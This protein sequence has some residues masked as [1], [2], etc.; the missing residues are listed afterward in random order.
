MD[1]RL[2]ADVVAKTGDKLRVDKPLNAVGRKLDHR[3][4]AD[5]RRKLNELSVAAAE[6]SENRNRRHKANG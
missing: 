4:R 3:F 5:H 6:S 2:T 1:H